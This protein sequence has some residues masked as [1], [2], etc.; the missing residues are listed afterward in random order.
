[1]P[2]AR[3]PMNVKIPAART[4][5]PASAPRSKRAPA[6]LEL[7]AVLPEDVAELLPEPDPE[8]LVPYRFICQPRK[9]EQV[10]KC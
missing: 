5:N 3:A 10:V 4:D 6:A 7:V 9:V 1:M 8:A 2:P